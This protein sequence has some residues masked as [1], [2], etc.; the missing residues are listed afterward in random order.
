V[1]YLGGGICTLTSS[2]TGESREQGQTQCFACL[3]QEC[4]HGCCRPGNHSSDS[5]DGP[6]CSSTPPCRDDS[7]DEEDDLPQA[8]MAAE[9]AEAATLSPL[10]PAG[11]P[12]QDAGI[13][14]PTLRT[15]QA[16]AEQHVGAASTPGPASQVETAPATQV[17][18]AMMAALAAIASLTPEQLQ[19]LKQL[20]AASRRGHHS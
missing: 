19:T 2:I 7:D 11:D 3:L 8:G 4:I 5:Y 10:Q 13:T 14:Q 20:A 18:P 15:T 17:T 1:L 9:P 6:T 16:G 12:V